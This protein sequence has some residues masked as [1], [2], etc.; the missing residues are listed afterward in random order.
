MEKTVQDR[1]MSTLENL[2]TDDLK[3]FKAKLNEVPVKRGYE[4]I[5]KGLLEKA[6]V[7]DLIDRLLS[8]Y[9]ETYAVQVTVK[10]LKVINCK[11][12]AEKLHKGNTKTACDSVQTPVQPTS[13]T[14]RRNG[15]TLKPPRPAE[16][17]TSPLVSLED[18]I[19]PATKQSSTR[20]SASKATKPTK[21]SAASK[22]SKSTSATSKATSASKP[23]ASKSSSSGASCSE[24]TKDPS[25][26]SAAP[27][28]PSFASQSPADKQT[29]KKS[30][31]LKPP[32]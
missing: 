16:P 30:K 3:K 2:Q 25:A 10:V 9:G 8:Y 5:P 28:V 21:S 24:A 19:P 1:L 14:S 31:K 4:N 15:P 13:A 18:T 22:A 23:S 11:G 26:S 20:S 12:Q 7:L 27:P 17:L 32:S 6:D 29:K